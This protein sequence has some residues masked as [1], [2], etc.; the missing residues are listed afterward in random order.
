MSQYTYRV[1][2]NAAVAKYFAATHPQPIALSQSVGFHKMVYS[3]LQSYAN[4]QTQKKRCE[5]QAYVVFA[6][7]ANLVKYHRFF[8]KPKHEKFVGNELKRM[9]YAALC[10]FVNG[11]ASGETIKDRIIAFMDLYGF[12]EEDVPFD[13]LKKYYY[14]YD[15]RFKEAIEPIL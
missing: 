8:M 14:R 4:I 7:S 1:P 15:R 13:T 11:R 12:T 6:L 10:A 2:V 9:M 3:S 5:A